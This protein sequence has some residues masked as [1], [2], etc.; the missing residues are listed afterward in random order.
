[1][2]NFLINGQ[3]GDAISVSDRGLHYGDGVF[4]TITIDQGQPLC[5]QQH[6]QRLE[7]GCNRLGITVPPPKVLLDEAQSLLSNS[8]REVIKLIITR[9]QG[10]R[11]YQAPHD[12]STTR[13]IGSYP[14]P[15]YSKLDP[16]SGVNVRLCEHRLSQNQNLA[17]IKH[18]NRLEQVLA[19]SEWVTEDYAEGLMLDIAGNIIEGTMSNIFLVLGKELLT[20]DL[21]FCGINGIVR[22]N[23]LS[24]ASNLGLI[25]KITTVNMETLIGADEMFLCNS[26]IGIWPVNEIG[27][28]FF[29]NMSVTMQIRDLLLQNRIITAY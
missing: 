1:M 19:R 25:S 6:L 9:G 4:E 28:H 10:G 27:G 23:I 29:K 3:P 16:L 13:I 8:A 12:M 15:D 11:G 18:L 26:V 24:L 7:Q 2:N 14:F 21:T 17:G 5:W 22:Q 20:P